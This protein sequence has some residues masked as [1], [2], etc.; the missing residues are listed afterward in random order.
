MG[1]CFPCLG[2]AA[3]QVVE[4]PDPAASRGVK[5][6][7]SVEQKKRKQEEM[8]KRLES[9]NQGPEGGNLRVRSEESNLDE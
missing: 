7:S 1:L 5:N 6:L 8:E 3:D 2:G 4:T 9:G